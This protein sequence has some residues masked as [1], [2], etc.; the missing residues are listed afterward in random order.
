MNTKLLVPTDF[1]EVAQSAMQH[2][3]KFAE[4][5]NADVILLHVVS[6]REEVEEAKEKLSKEITL[7]SSFS[8]SCNVTSFV[9]IGNI[10]ED[11]G[12]V[13][14]ELGISLIFMGTH[15]AS[16]WQKLVG[17]RAIK[18]ITSSPVPFIVTQEKLMNSNGYDNIVVPLDLNVETK[19]K[20]E[21]VAKIAHYFDSQVHLL[22]NDNS[23][24]FIKTKLKANQVWASNYLESKDIKNSSHLVDQADSL[25]EG[26]F[27]LSKEVDADLIAIM[28][29]ADET[30]LGLYE[31]SFQ[32]E[33]VAND[34]KVPVLCVNPHPVTKVS[35]ILVR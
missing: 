12:D 23:D 4:I 19:Q 14:A 26:I 1:S 32:E 20:L 15:K 5:I 22:T 31:N 10:F 18:V 27:K 30:V 28:N 3:I 9:R 25:T 21:L 11:I 16:R 13:A 33:I 2:A 35:G 29:L 6:S 7:G 17:S 34:L 24:E 8:G